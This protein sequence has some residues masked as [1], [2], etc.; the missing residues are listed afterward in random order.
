MPHYDPFREM[1]QVPNAIS[2]PNRTKSS[3]KEM[4]SPSKSTPKT[5]LTR[6]RLTLD[7]IERDQIHWPGG[8][9][10]PRGLSGQSEHGINST[11]N[12]SGTASSP[13]QSPVR[14]RIAYGRCTTCGLNSPPRSNQ[15]DR[16]Q[17]VYINHS[18]IDLHCEEFCPDIE[19]PWFCQTTARSSYSGESDTN[20]D[21]NHHSS[22][23]TTKR[24]HSLLRKCCDIGLDNS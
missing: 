24:R 4:S 17:S 23:P 2:I 16:C 8:Q 21:S 12:F 1:E 5:Q 10:R 6:R 15:D 13:L 7:N 11:R 3:P 22:R 18:P 20:S 14:N 19:T 9:N